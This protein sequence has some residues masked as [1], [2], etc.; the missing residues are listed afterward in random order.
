MEPGLSSTAVLTITIIDIND[1]DPIF[2]HPVYY[3][4]DIVENTLTVNIPV[5]ASDNDIGSNAQ[6]TYVIASGNQNSA[7]VIG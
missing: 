1:N 6:L 3:D 4:N 2:E 7:F 5:S